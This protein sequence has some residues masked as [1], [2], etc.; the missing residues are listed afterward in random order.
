MTADSEALVMVTAEEQENMY[1][2]K[3]PQTPLYQEDAGWVYWLRILGGM[4]LDVA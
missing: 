1:G 3:A 2:H 4:C